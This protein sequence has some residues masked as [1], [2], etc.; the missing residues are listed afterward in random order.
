MV[1]NVSVEHTPTS[2]LKMDAEYYSETLVPTYY[3][4]RRYGIED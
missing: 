2:T 3:A 4:R 1:I